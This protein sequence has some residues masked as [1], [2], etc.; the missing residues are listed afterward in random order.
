MNECLDNATILHQETLSALHRISHQI[1]PFNLT[2]DKSCT[3]QEVT[4]LNSLVNILDTKCDSAVNVGTASTGI[5]LFLQKENFKVHHIRCSDMEELCVMS[6]SWL[7]FGNVQLL[8]NVK[9]NS[10][11]SELKTKQDLLEMLIA[12]LKLLKIGGTFICHL[13][14]LLLRFTTGLVYILHYLFESITVVKPFVS[15]LWHPDR[16]LVCKGFQGCST[17]IL[18]YLVAIHSK[19]VELAAS[20]DG[21]EDVLE[22]VPMKHLY[23]QRF[24]KFIKQSN[25]KIAHLQ[26]QNIIRLES[27]FLTS[28]SC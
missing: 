6:S 3:E 4:T 20:S 15:R 8:D 13:S 26:I 7:V 28:H 18:N 27:L 14:E 17:H 22:I 25:E 1:F 12:A 21:A 2:Y 24:F 5:E 23:E 10:F 19:I 16:Y 9:T 11:C